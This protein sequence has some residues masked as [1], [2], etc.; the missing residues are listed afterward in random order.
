MLDNLSSLCRSGK[1][2][3]AD[4]WQP[5]QDFLLRMR[6]KGVSVLL[7]HHAG[8]GGQQRGTSRREDVL[9][10]VIALRRPADYEAVEG[11]RFEIHIEKSR[12]VM[13]DKLAPFEAK[14][15][16]CNSAVVWS[17]KSLADVEK[18]RVAELVA[19]GL[20]V[21]EIAAELGVSVGKAHKLKK[22]TEAAESVK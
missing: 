7:V 4:S 11:A 15:E 3:E 22:K 5:V 2:N 17:R 9:D 6:R 18:T 21:R 8:K 13:G 19:D 1:E 14:L 10:T 16:V 12:G 20:T